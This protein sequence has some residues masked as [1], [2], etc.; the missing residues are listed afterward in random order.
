MGVYNIS[1][2]VNARIGAGSL[3]DI[4]KTS[5]NLGMKKPLIVCDPMMVKIGYSKKLT[6][7]LSEA[8][9]EWS[10][11]DNCV[12]NPTTTDVEKGAV[13]YKEKG[14][15]GIIALGGG[16]P[17]DQAKGI[18][19]LS[20][21]GGTPQDY[22]VVGGSR[23]VEIKADMAPMIAIPT[24]SGT[25]SEV[26]KAAV[27]TDTGRNV[28]FFLAN[29]F[30]YPSTV[31]LDPELTK[32]MPP[33]V[34]AATG[35]DALVHALEAYVTAG[36]NPISE[37]FGRTAFMLIGKSLKK[38]VDQGEDLDART[39][40]SMASMVA[41]I[42]F[43]IAG[44]GAVHALAHPL[45]GRHH[46]AH[47]LANSIMMPHVLRYNAKTSEDR[48]IEALKYMGLE[49]SSAEE[50]AVALT[51][52]SK[53]IGL[54]TKLSEIGIKADDLAQLSKDAVADVNHYRNPVKCTEESLLGI[55]KQAL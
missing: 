44:L 23:A 26:T 43:D 48:Y 20:K 32:S 46:I 29:P 52:F 24:T 3:N 50:A 9:L 36:A 54:P 19:V 14:C 5:Q 25:G 21:Y 8:A 42:S 27:I 51:K 39:D 4:G 16:S 35:M 34:T 22:N 15:D 12:E 41:G 49:V 10:V 31:I 11:Y 53:D 6:G 40:M 30:L 38:A 1:V 37:S 33:N 2:G 13:E 55:Y 17:M 7:L 28:K 45:G 47:G 18:R